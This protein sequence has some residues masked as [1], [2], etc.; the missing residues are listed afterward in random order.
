MKAPL[1]P[2]PLPAGEREGR[3]SGERE[4]RGDEKN[5]FKLFFNDK[6]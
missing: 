3:K 4:E 5:F 6:I 1:T 2:T